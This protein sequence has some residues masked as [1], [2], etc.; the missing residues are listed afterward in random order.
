MEERNEIKNL[1]ITLII[2]ISVLLVFYFITVFIT[3][4]QNEKEIDNDTD[5]SEAVIDYDTIL[6][7]EIYKQKQTSYY[8]L[9]AIPEDENV[10]SYEN[11]LTSYSNGENSLKVY[12]VDLSSAL[13]KKYISEVTDLNG[14]FPLFSETT[15]LK[16]ENGKI[17]ENYQGED[18]DVFL[19]TLP[20][21]E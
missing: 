16:I 3:K 5:I 12:Q 7:S 4:N 19:K 21:E 17:V 2:I 10:T 8:V 11:T 18:I 15:L 9:V 20:I 1:I 6:V 13:N 14:K